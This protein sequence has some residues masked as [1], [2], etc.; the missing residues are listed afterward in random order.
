MSVLLK[1]HEGDRTR[2]VAVLP[3]GRSLTIGRAEHNDVAFQTDMQMSSRHATLK[4]LEDQCILTDLDSTN[5]TWV[6]N[7]SVRWAE[8]TDGS[9]FRCGTTE[10]ILEWLS[11][12]A[13]FAPPIAQKAAPAANEA[14]DPNITVLAPTDDAPPPAVTK[15]KPELPPNATKQ[16]P[17][18]LDKDF[19][20]HLTSG[21]CRPLASQ[22]FDRF[23]LNQEI[24]L[25]PED[26]ETP[27]QFIERLLPIK[28]GAEVIHFLAF[29]LPRRRAV[30]WLVQCLRSDIELTDLETQVLDLVEA[31][32]NDPTEANRV[33]PAEFVAEHS[34]EGLTTWP[35]QAAFYSHG[36]VTP[37]N[38]PKVPPKDELAGKTV[39]AGISLVIVDCEPA[40]I[41]DR[42]HTCIQRALADNS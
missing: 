26:G 1:V 5:G 21:F 12:P 23:Q 33:A 35:A 10:F 41:V 32:I 3:F 15:P 37:P 36:S 17:A 38:C 20:L 25:T 30:M 13:A 11:G 42:R 22:I 2:D 19:D 7:K 4:L 6:G 39:L 18:D 40:E 24:S 14:Y 8:V 28:D 34:I 9:S 31:W 16:A 27:Q 29:A